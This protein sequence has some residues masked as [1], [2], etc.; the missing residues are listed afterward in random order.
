M[1]EFDPHRCLIEFTP[2]PLG[3]E[4]LKQTPNGPE[5]RRVLPYV[6]C[7]VSREIYFQ[8]ILIEMGLSARAPSHANKAS[9]ILVA[10]RPEQK[11]EVPS[12]TF[13]GT[14]IKVPIFPFYLYVNRELF[15]PQAPNQ[16]PV[17]WMEMMTRRTKAI[18]HELL[19]AD[20]YAKY[21]DPVTRQMTRALEIPTVEQED[22]LLCP[23]QEIEVTLHTIEKTFGCSFE[24]A[25][26]FVSQQAT[27]M[28]QNYYRVWLEKGV[29]RDVCHRRTLAYLSSQMRQALHSVML[30]RLD[31][32]GNN[33][34]VTD[35]QLK[36]H[37]R[38][39]SPQWKAYVKTLRDEGC[40]CSE[41][42][43]LEHALLLLSRNR[44]RH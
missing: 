2:K 19:Y 35:L 3:E 41:K 25:D 15:P 14:M 36:T 1:N 33:G 43:I 40:E 9:F 21:F 7:G 16:N 13:D 31:A 24:T 11:K 38:E 18:A 26:G 27:V 8:P 10:F 22:E 34:N 29:E 4:F 6:S 20:A 32:F 37:Y 5:Y 44:H 12:P 23:S 28:V 17:E 39:K 42:E 30:K